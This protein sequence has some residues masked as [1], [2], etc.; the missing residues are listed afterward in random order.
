MQCGILDWILEQKEKISGKTDKNL[1][2]VYNLV[3]SIVPMK[4]F[5][6]CLF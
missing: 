4:M 1:N 6:F 5:Q 3:I 2:E